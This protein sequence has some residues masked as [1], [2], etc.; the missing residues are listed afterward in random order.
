MLLSMRNSRIAAVVSGLLLASLSLSCSSAGDHRRVTVYRAQAPLQGVAE[1]TPSTPP[2]AEISSAL[3]RISP[4]RL[5]TAVDALAAFGTRHTLS[6]TTSPTRGIGAAREWIKAQFEQIAAE[7]GRT[8]DM[9][10]QVYFDTHLVPPDGRRVF[11]E[12][13]LVNVICVIPGRD[14]AKRDRLHYATAHYDS[15]CG[16]HND[17]ECDAPGANDN[18]S[19]TAVLFELARAALANPCDATVVLVATAGEEQGLIGARHHAAAARA[20][21]LRIVSVLNNDI[22]GDPLGSLFGTSNE[23]AKSWARAH[24]RVF[25]EGFPKDADADAIRRI[26]ALGLE[27]DS[28]SRTL[29]RY[30]I[31]TAQR[32]HLDVRPVMVY[33]NDRFLR[34]GDHSAFIENGFPAAVRFTVTNEE[35]DRQHQYVRDETVAV[36][37]STTHTGEANPR[38]SIS[39]ETRVVRFGDR[40]EYVDEHY[41]AGVARVNAAAILHLANAPDTPANARII[42]ASLT[43]DT[44]LRWSHAD[45]ADGYEILIRDTTAPDWQW[46]VDAG[47]V[48]EITLPLSKDNVLFAVR[49]YNR[50]GFRS[51]PAVTGAARE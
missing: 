31:E 24:V 10:V 28:P 21:G 7:S 27:N 25:S 26:T 29:A 40:P 17:A 44:T 11:R 4:R 47:R 32:H 5:R 49:A 41:L 39:S 46:R 14:A 51:L 33:R 6:D 48:N 43:N 35:Y 3:T 22:V 1:A 37:T 36:T 12:V 23:S 15:I 19:G 2:P 34:G 9:A 8:G 50:R 38:F 18:A 42:T 20:R 16:E 13:E 30:V 45:G